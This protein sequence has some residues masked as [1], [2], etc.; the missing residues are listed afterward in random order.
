[1]LLPP[2]VHQEQDGLLPRPWHRD[3]LQ[4]GAEMAGF[5]AKLPLIR[6]LLLTHAEVEFLW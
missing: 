4:H 3:L 2:Q 6:A 5:W 1:V